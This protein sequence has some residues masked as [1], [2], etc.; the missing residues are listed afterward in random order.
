MYA[1]IFLAVRM[2]FINFELMYISHRYTIPDYKFSL[3]LDSF[4]AGVRY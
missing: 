1:E 2:L 4:S 3:A